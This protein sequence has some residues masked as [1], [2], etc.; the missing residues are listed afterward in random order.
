MKKKLFPGTRIPEVRTTERPSY[1]TLDELRGRR[2]FLVEAGQTLLGG[3]ALIALLARAGAGGEPPPD[4]DDKD[5]GSDGKKA[6]KK[7]KDKEKK[8]PIPR[9]GGVGQPR[10]RGD[11][12]EE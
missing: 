2:R 5:K 12:P 9:P 10:A 8:R 11:A 6:K 1:P 3:A 7:D 4:P